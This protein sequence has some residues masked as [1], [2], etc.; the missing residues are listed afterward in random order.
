MV[1]CHKHIEMVALLLGQG[2]DINACDLVRRTDK[3]VSG[4]FTVPT[5]TRVMW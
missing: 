3:S 5:S 1:I 4:Q 2:A